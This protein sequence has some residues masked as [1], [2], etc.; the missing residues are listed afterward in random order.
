MT[1]FTTEDRQALDDG[2]ARCG[3]GKSLHQPYCDGS[4]ARSDQ[5]LK[6]WKDKCDLEAYQRQAAEIWSDSCT[7]PRKQK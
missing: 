1:T 2:R 7:T 4:H 5:Q 6:E 3:C